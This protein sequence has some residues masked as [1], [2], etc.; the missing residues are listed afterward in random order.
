MIETIFFSKCTKELLKETFGLHQIWT[1]PLLDEWFERAEAINPEDFEL[2]VLEVIRHTLI[3]RCDDW[4]EFELSEHFIGPLIAIV[5]FNTDYFSTFLERPL[6]AEVGEYKLMG[7]P[8]LM[9]AKGETTPKI[10]YFCFQEYKKQIDPEGNPLYQA[11]GEMLAAA[12]LHPSKH[13][14]YGV[15]VIGKL[16]HFV[17]LQGKEYAIS[18]GFLADDEDIV[19][20]FKILKALKIILIEIAKHDV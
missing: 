14:I 18:K 20:I 17:I 16:W 11:L 10:P 2:K 6:E 5:D 1:S 19:T 3:R 7:K 8:D 9:V 13:P 12:S 15:G 4:N